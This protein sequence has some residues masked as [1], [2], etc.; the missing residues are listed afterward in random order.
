[1]K[2]SIIIILAVV[3]ILVIWAVSVYN[4]LV[5]MDE[6]VSGQWAAGTIGLIRPLSRC[7]CR[8]CNRIR[9]TADGCLKPCLHSREEISVRGL[10]GPD[11]RRRLEQAIRHKPKQHS[12]LSASARSESARGMNQIG[13]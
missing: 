5:T 9:L 13:G 1:M 4:G 2:K 8:Q 6:N 7:F 10:H 11:L 12:Q 3:A